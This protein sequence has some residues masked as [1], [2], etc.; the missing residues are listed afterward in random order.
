M[1][2]KVFGRLRIHYWF[3]HCLGRQVFGFWA[4]QGK[5]QSKKYHN[6]IHRPPTEQQGRPCCSGGWGIWRRCPAPPLAEGAL[7][8][9][10]L[11]PKAALDTPS[12][13]AGVHRRAGGV[14]HP[15]CGPHP[16]GQW[17]CPALVL[18]G[19]CR[20]HMSRG[21][22]VRWMSQVTW[23]PGLSKL[24]S[25]R[26]THHVLMPPVE[27]FLC[28]ATETGAVCFRLDLELKAC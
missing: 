15:L 22:C 13:V 2:G 5:R 11:T 19:S 9:G 23:V 7:G 17:G 1:F 24:R 16:V 28:G 3:G 20:M 26:R 14:C 12:T 18:R 25:C 10:P 4:A 8:G 21:P 27:A 6:F